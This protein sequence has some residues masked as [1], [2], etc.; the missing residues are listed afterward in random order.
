MYNLEFQTFT[1]TPTA[2]LECVAI[3]ISHFFSRKSYLRFF[4]LFFFFFFCIYDNFA[5]VHMCSSL[6]RFGKTNFKVLISILEKHG[7]N[8]LKIYSNKSRETD[9]MYFQRKSSS[10]IFATF[11]ID[12]AKKKNPGRQC[13]KKKKRRIKDGKQ[14]GRRIVVFCR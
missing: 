13:R 9:G 11:L 14:S 1:T 2:K 5:Q 8:F 12:F 10:S 4:F 7:V 3:V 6:D